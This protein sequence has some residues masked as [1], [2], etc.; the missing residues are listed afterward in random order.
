MM[1]RIKHKKKMDREA[2]IVLEGSTEIQT[3]SSVAKYSYYHQ[4]V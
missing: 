2:V 3:T 1:N 4:I